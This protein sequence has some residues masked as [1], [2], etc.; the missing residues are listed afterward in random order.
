MTQE[1]V[2]ET[3]FIYSTLRVKFIKSM[4]NSHRILAVRETSP[5]YST[6]KPKP[7]KAPVS[8]TKGHLSSDSNKVTRHRK[9]RDQR[10]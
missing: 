9:Q 5:D 6:T 1:V 2:Q 3:S 10:S 8:D 4:T 7:R